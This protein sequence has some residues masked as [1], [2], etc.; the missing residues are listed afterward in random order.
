AGA[1]LGA[2]GDRQRPGEA[3]THG[4]LVPGVDGEV[5][6]EVVVR[7]GAPDLLGVGLQAGR[8][9]GEVGDQAG[10]GAGPA[11]HVLDALGDSG[12]QADVDLRPLPAGLADAVADPADLPVHVLGRG[13]AHHDRAVGE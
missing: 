4:A 11:A 10:L 1:L 9:L 3:V 12:Q 5:L 6:A 13:G 8:Q 2:P 7:L